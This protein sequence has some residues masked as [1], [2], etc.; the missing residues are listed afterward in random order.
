MPPKDHFTQLIGKMKFGLVFILSFFTATVDAQGLNRPLNILLGNDDGFESPYLQTMFT[1]LK[2]AG[3]NVIMSAP[4]DNKSGT[5]STLEV[6]VPYATTSH[7]S[8][9]GTIAAG[10]PGVGPTTLGPNQYS[11]ME[12]SLPLRCT[13]STY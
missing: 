8:Q 4:Y 11:S 5:S 12:L 9:G 6:F 7:E 2:A 1:A 10:A 3:H 13:A